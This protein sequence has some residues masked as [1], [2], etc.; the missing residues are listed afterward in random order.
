VSLAVRARA[1]F[2]ANIVLGASHTEMLDGQGIDLYNLV[3]GTG[4]FNVPK[5]RGRSAK[6]AQAAALGPGLL[7]SGLN[8]GT[9]TLRATAS[10]PKGYKGS[11]TYTIHVM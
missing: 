2:D 4:V 10:V 5:V 8:T 3:T 7:L 9:H 1:L 6:T 11:V